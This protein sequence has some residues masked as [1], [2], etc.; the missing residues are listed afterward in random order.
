MVTVWRKLAACNGMDVDIFF[1]ARKGGDKEKLAN[2]REI[3]GWCPVR[4]ECLDYAIASDSSG[5]WGGLTEE[6]RR[7]L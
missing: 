5:V 7:N 2:A 6:E 4:K 3:C 1:P